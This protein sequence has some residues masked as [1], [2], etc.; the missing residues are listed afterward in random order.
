MGPNDGIAFVV[1][2]FG[3]SS[4]EDE[5]LKDDI[6][7]LVQTGGLGE[8]SDDDEG[9]K[10]DGGDAEEEDEVRTTLLTPFVVLP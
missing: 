3:S 6:A 5:T 7:R 9:V 10:A 4:E 8:D 1:M 2:E